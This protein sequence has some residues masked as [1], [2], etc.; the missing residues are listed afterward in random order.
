MKDE[1][2][3]KTVD[4]LGDGKATAARSVGRPRQ[5]VD[6][7]ARQAAYRLRLKSEGKR[8][9]S[10][11]VKDVRKQDVPLTSRII[12]LSAIRHW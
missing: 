7:A 9:V 6:S 4:F 8:V 10:R 5:F 3:S 1:K 11:I 12:D 2:D